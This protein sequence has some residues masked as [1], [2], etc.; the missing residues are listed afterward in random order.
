MLVYEQWALPYLTVPYAYVM[1]GGWPPQAWSGG[2]S[3]N[4]LA[5]DPEVAAFFGSSETPCE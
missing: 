4:E 3:W 5:D 1:S 2:A